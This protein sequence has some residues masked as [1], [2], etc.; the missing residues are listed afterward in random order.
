MN[1]FKTFDI[2]LRE[3]LSILKKSIVQIVSISSPAINDSGINVTMRDNETQINVVNNE[4]IYKLLKSVQKKRENL[5]AERLRLPEKKAVFG[6]L[7]LKG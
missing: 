1:I 3:P 2:F 6:A 5:A 7:T 4:K